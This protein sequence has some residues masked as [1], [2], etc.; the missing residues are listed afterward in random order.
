MSFLGSFSPSLPESLWGKCDKDGFR[1]NLEEKRL[2]VFVCVILHPI[3]VFIWVH[4]ILG[5][6]MLATLGMSW[7]FYG[8][9]E[10]I[11]KYS[12][13]FSSK[14]RPKNCFKRTKNPRARDWSPWISLPSKPRRCHRRFPAR[15]CHRRPYLQRSLR[16][17]SGFETLSQP[18]FMFCKNNQKHIKIWWQLLQNDIKVY[19]GSYFILSHLFA[20]FVEPPTHFLP[21]KHSRQPENPSPPRQLSRKFRYSFLES[22]TW[23][24]MF[25]LSNLCG[26]CGPHSKKVS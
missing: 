1:S 11:T 19:G 25:L 16:S 12:L 17:M 3:S 20:I 21:P 14:Q 10:E 4:L 23:R 13:D 26:L 9:K 22:S 7:D 18:T 6:E 15:P 24:C 5:R 8:Q 2:W